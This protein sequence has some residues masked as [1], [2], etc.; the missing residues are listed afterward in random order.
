MIFTSKRSWG[1]SLCFVEILLFVALAMVGNQGCR[2]MVNV[3]T[4]PPGA[5]GSTG[6]L[7]PT[8]T[9]AGPS[10]PTT[11]TTT[12]TNPAAPGT[13]TTTQGGTDRLPE[14]TFFRWTTTELVGQ[15]V[16]PVDGGALPVELHRGYASSTTGLLDQGVANLTLPEASA[17]GHAFKFNLAGKGLNKGDIV[18]VKTFSVN[19]QRMRGTSPDPL[20]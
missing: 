11:T 2:V 14:I 1:H 7:S 20:Q 9:V 17:Q 10:S 12:V 13:T 16:D 15:A 8:T 18:T 4:P 19:K 3:G 6:P 5:P